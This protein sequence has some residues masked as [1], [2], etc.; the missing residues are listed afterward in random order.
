MNAPPAK[1]PSWLRDER[2]VLA[3]DDRFGVVGARRHA[4]RPPRVCAP[5]VHSVA[6]WRLGSWEVDDRGRSRRKAPGARHTRVTI[7]VS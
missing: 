4:R 5:T 7:D 6:V 3:K 2:I 1:A